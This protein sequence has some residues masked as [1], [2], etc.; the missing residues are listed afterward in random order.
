M[1]SRLTQRMPDG[2]VT[3]DPSLM[4]HRLADY[5]DTG[6]SPEDIA[7]FKRLNA[8]LA[9]MGKTMAYVGE[10]MAATKEGRV[11]LFKPCNGKCCGNC[12]H[13][14]RYAGANEFYATG[15]CEIKSS[16]RKAICGTPVP[17]SVSNT[18]PACKDF[19]DRGRKAIRYCPI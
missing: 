13:F 4:I 17:R 6:Y 14:L 9:S 12:N 16:S 18:Y 7:A 19:A 11:K 15:I 2:T 8:E 5:E 1:L 3:A 10:L